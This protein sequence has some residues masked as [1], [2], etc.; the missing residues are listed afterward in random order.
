M[1]Q[2]AVADELRPHIRD[3]TPPEDTTVVVRGGPNSIEKLVRHAVRMNR[4]YQLDGRAFWGVSVFLALDET[5]EASISGLLSG[6][7]RTFR[8]VHTPILGQLHTAGFEV[9][10]TFRRPHFTLV[11]P[12]AAPGTLERLLS[13]LGPGAVNPYHERGRRR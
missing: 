9:L 11:I 4:A 12:D 1:K 2:A 10:P 6:R 7:M 3:D 8:I 5:G 13:A